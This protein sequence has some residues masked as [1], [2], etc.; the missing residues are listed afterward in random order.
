MVAK[1]KK[2]TI[3]RGSKITGVTILIK[4]CNHLFVFNMN[5]T[6]DKIAAKIIQSFLVKKPKKP[7]VVILGPTASGKTKLSL[8]L[9][10][11]FKGEIISADSRLIYR[12]L[13]IGA[14]KPTKK[15]Q[16]RTPHHLIDVAD[17]G[18]TFTLA[19]FVDQSLACLKKIYNK[20]KIP[21]LVGGTGLY[22][23]ALVDNFDLPRI[24]P[25]QQLRSQLEKLTPE[26]LF[27][28]LK[29]LNPNSAGKTDPK[30]SRY[31]IRAI[32]L[33]LSGK[34]KKDKRKK[35][36]FKV[37]KIGLRDQRL[38][39]YSRLGIRA[40]QQ[41]A[42]GVIEETKKI[43]KLGVSPKSPALSGFVYKEVVEYLNKKIT[44]EKAIEKVSQKNRNYA[45][46]QMT[47]FRKDSEINWI[48]DEF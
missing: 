35:R 1:V 21:F 48:G 17:P 16:A 28:K 33:A 20:N 27:K 12:G 3:K 30:N 6:K 37:I 25:N 46:R 22:I 44:L 36:K 4:I 26:K 18:T 11:K 39:L 7:L 40:R 42:D 13:D 38:K 24:A 29:K 34:P 9:A 23:D 2:N 31:L 5:Q 45:K 15:E 47:W 43:L 32:E 8:K 10:K 19:D 41:F 14:A